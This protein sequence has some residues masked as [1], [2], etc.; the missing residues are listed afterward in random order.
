M[1]HGIEPAAA[2]RAAGG[3]AEL[4]AALGQV[5]AVVIEQLGGEGSGADPGGVGLGDAQHVVQVERARRRSRWR[6]PPAVVLE[7][8]TKG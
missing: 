4:V 8:V 3:G 7:L 6:C 1:C 2:A 5:A